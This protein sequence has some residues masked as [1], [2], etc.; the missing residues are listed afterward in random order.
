MY[1]SVHIY[2]ASMDLTRH[3]SCV[4]LRFSDGPPSC[5]MCDGGV[6]DMCNSV[7][8]APFSL[9]SQEI[10]LVGVGIIDSFGDLVPPRS[11]DSQRDGAM[12]WYKREGE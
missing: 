4:H 9:N 5:D 6:M 3:E 11:L 2:G 10:G 12:G 8:E 1:R 7:A